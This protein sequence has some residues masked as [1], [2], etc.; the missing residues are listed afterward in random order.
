MSAHSG[1]RRITFAGVIGALGIVYG[2]IG[3]SPL[4]AMNT[5]L[6]AAAGGGVPDASM[7]LGVLSLVFW[8]LLVVVTLKYVVLILRA[9]NQGEGGILSLFALVQRQLTT[10]GEWRRYIVILAVMGAALYYCDALIT[11]AISVMSAVE[12]LELL[13]EGMSESIV[14][15]TLV[16][17]VLLFSIQRYGT[18]K[19][20]SLFGPVM[21]TWFL[22]LGVTGGMSLAQNPA[23]LAALNPVHAVQMLGISPAISMAVIGSVFLTLTGG[24]A[25]YADMGHFGKGPVRVAWFGMVWP[26][27]LLNY[28][29]QGA[30]QLSH[31]G[32]PGQLLYS[33]IP[34][35]VLPAVVIL[36]TAATVIASQ[37]TITSAFSMTRQAVQLDFLP[38]VRV[39]QTSEHEEGQI[40]VP[41]I[42]SLIMVA[43]MVFVVSF[44]SSAALAG[45]YGAAVAGTM[46]ITTMLG[47]ILAATAWNWPRWRVLMTFLPLGIIDSAFLIGNFAKIAEGAWVPMLL[48]SILFTI[49]MIW[50]SG[51]QQLRKALAA[52]AIPME[53]VGELLEGVTRV[54]GNAVFLAS[55]SKYV[56]SAL[57]RNLEHNHI[58]HEHVVILNLEIA[59]TPRQDPADRV[60]IEQISPQI[61]VLRARFGYMETPDVSEALKQAR[62]RGLKLFVDDCSFFVGWHRVLPRTRVGYVGLKQRIFA[63]LQGRSTQA[64]EFFR[65]PERRVIALVTQVEI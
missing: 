26:C 49:F 60:K 46:A 24:E 37:A 32:K 9:D 59:R 50:R 31:P 6:N 18:A 56:P 41:I 19:V 35:P 38:R 11:P 28:F 16:V 15:V 8:S 51:R 36:A 64:S 40:Y 5:A 34:E 10:A 44:G 14:P 17:L 61:S 45:A 23:V 20:G 47:C 4:Y 30:Y 48:S 12:G 27:L 54:P 57:L 2:D 29:G 55:S 3:T 58:V 33:I 63:W 53:K 42:N 25:L 7:V 65:M 39:L 52:E 62:S 43:V 22:T 21:V 1:N 13:D